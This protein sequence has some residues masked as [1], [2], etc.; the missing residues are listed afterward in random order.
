[1]PL[2]D[3]GEVAKV[4]SF[5][6]KSHALVIVFFVA[7]LD[8]GLLA[9]PPIDTVKASFRVDETAL[10]QPGISGSAVIGGKT[11]LMVDVI[12][13]VE[14]LHP[15]WFSVERQMPHRVSDGKT[16][17]L[18]ED[19]K[20]FRNQIKCAIQDA[21]YNVLEAE[22]GMIAWDLLQKNADLV[23]CVVTDLEMPNLDGFGFARRIK[24][25]DR[26]S[27]LPVVAVSSLAGKDDIKKAKDSGVD[28][29][30]IKL[31][32]R[33]LVQCLDHYLSPH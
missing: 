32:R 11:T 9:I 15:E 23:S 16:V 4:P 5:Q 18:A 19:S 21:G 29:Y 1:M 27:H 20:F 26:F 31:D 30:Q 22:D 2:F 28:Q 25:D 7:G 6:S 24:S 12:G 8:I 17:I 33:K 14:T 3:V 10:K 13:I